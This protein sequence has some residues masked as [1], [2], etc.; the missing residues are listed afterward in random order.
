MCVGKFRG[1]PVSAHSHVPLVPGAPS[2]RT[3][4]RRRRSRSSY[5]TRKHRLILRARPFRETKHAFRPHELGRTDRVSLRSRPADI[6]K[7]SKLEPIDLESKR[8]A[9]AP[10]GAMHLNMGRAP[11]STGTVRIVLVLGRDHVKAESDRYLHRLEKMCR[12][13][14]LAQSSRTR[15]PQYV[16]RC[17][18]PWVRAR[19]EKLRIVPGAL[20]V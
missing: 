5:R 2:S 20:P 6:P 3:T 19:V 11:A 10:R 15:P 4:R 7:T 18:T 12:A 13:R 16:S 9:R 14:T 17:S 1:H 8:R